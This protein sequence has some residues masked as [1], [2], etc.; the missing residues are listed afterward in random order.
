LAISK[1]YYRQYMAL[2]LKLSTDLL[3]TFRTGNFLWQ[4]GLSPGSGSSRRTL[5]LSMTVLMD[6]S[7]MQ[8]IPDRWE[9]TLA[10]WRIEMKIKSCLNRQWCEYGLVYMWVICMHLEDIEY[11][12]IVLKELINVWKVLCLCYLL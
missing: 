2:F 4:G 8:K 10:L 12:L 5:K 1:I 11:P 6:S 9:V 3:S 7:E